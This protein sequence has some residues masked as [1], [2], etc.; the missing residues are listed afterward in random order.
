MLRVSSK[1]TLPDVAREEYGL[2]G[3]VFLSRA[4]HKT[5]YS[6]KSKLPIIYF[7]KQNYRLNG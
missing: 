1:C 2:A 4:S 6:C 3:V 5:I 7:P